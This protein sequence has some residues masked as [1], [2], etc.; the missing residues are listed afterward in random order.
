MILDSTTKSVEV[1][2]SANVASNQAV[3]YAAF[4][5][6]TTSTLVGGETDALSNNTTAV[7]AV[8]APAASTQ[9]Q[10]KYLSIYNNDTAAITVTVR[11]NN[12]G[13][14]RI[15]NK[16]TLL[17]GQALQWTADQGFAI[18]T[19]LQSVAPDFVSG[20]KLSWNSASSL[21]SSSGECWIPGANALW[22]PA[23]TLTLPGL[24]L[25]N[26]VFGHVYAYF[27]ASVPSIECVTTAP[28]APYVGTARTK[29][30]DT[31][32]RYLGSVL[33][34][35]SGNIFNFQHM[36][37]GLMLY[38]TSIDGSQFKVLIGNA[39]TAT[40]V[41]CASCVP[42]TG[43]RALANIINNDTTHV[44][45]LGNSN[46]VPSTTNYLEQIGTGS[47]GTTIA[48]EILLDGSQAFQYIFAAGAA[49][50]LVVRVKGYAFE[51]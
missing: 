43:I 16:S 15:L 41:S 17:P 24:A 47:S 45:Y 4:A 21:S 49:A 8:A 34:D 13:T 28:S 31:T 30:G 42:S 12:N 44:A 35:A 38:Q 2:L 39:T 29:S 51:R 25:G 10:V 36:T 20:A 46:I 3:I 18:P 33:T 40:S 50:N 32:R 22:Q 9:R 19:A 1:L 6:M 14:F 26:S 7:T 5:D 23:A 27:N 37:A 48:T 11:L